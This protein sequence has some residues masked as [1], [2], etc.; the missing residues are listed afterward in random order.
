MAERAEAAAAP[1]AGG[2]AA[3]QAIVAA[4]ATAFAL[5]STIARLSY[6]GGMTALG[7]NLARAAVASLA[8]ALLLRLARVPLGLEPRVRNV[9]LACGVL[10]AAYSYAL[11]HALYYVPV[12]LAVITFYTFPILTGIVAWTT[13]RQPFTPRSAGGLA[14]AFVGLVLALGI[15]GAGFD[16]R[17]IG[18]AFF[19]AVGLT[20]VVTVIGSIVPG[21]DSRPVTLHMQTSAALCFAAAAALT[22]AVGRPEA[23][24]GW[25]GLV[26][27]PL[28]Y[29]FSFTAFY[30]GIARIGPM[31][32]S[33]I[34]NLE[35]VGSVLFGWLLLGQ[36]LGP[37]QL[38]GIALVVVALY[39]VR[40]PG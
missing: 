11:F 4:A 16:A 35:P 29:T 17:G 7:L 8:L 36:T 10:T 23:P 40:K 34:M 18:L 32:A 26:V 28:L 25:L 20:V 5:N 19:A 24:V 31:R 9:A 37:L 3:G 33:A 38:A 22:G 6:D 14:L 39:L 2:L 12:A 15:G 30:A 1:A 27:V 21:R 13:G